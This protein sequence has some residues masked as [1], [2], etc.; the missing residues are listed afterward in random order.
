MRK[1]PAFML[2]L[3]LSPQGFALAEEENNWYA[4]TALG[5]MLVHAGLG[6]SSNDPFNAGLLVGYQFPTNSPWAIEAMY[7]TTVRDGKLTKD[8]GLQYDYYQNW[9]IDT[10]GI[11]GVFRTPDSWYFKARGGFA[12][13]QITVNTGTQE[14]SE[15]RTSFS[16]GVGTGWAFGNFRVEADYTYLEKDVDFLSLSLLRRF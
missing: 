4:G 2:V 8:I 3:V 14:I 9:N 12:G 10:W 13:D 7:T 6:F 11:Y 1:I 15:E 5:F 16:V